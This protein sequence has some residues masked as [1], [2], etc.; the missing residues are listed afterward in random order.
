VGSGVEEEDNKIEDRDNTIFNLTM[1]LV[2]SVFVRFVPFAL[3]LFNNLLT[4]SAEKNFLGLDDA[5]LNNL[6][7][8]LSIVPKACRAGQ[9]Q[10]FKRSVPIAATI[11]FIHST[12]RFKDK[13]ALLCCK[14]LDSFGA[15]E[16]KSIL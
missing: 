13:F 10:D 5:T 4:S 6:F 15:A 3:N 12:G 8:V 9:L 1:F 7:A 2:D 16:V 11:Q 14:W